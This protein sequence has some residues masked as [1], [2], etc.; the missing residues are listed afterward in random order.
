MTRGDLVYS[1]INVT[2]CHFISH[3]IPYG[4]HRVRIH[5]N[6]SLRMYVYSSVGS[7]SAIL[8]SVSPA[9][10]ILFRSYAALSD[11]LFE[12]PVSNLAQNIMCSDR[13]VLS[14]ELITGISRNISPLPLTSTSILFHSYPIIRPPDVW[15]T[16]SVIKQSTNKCKLRS[17][18]H[19]VC[20]W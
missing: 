4:L 7:G 14:L 12:L 19:N 5:A 16:D 1:K 10:I 13:K 17:L 9:R 3:K 8:T 11:V 2:Q 18:F 20:S 15:F 6:S